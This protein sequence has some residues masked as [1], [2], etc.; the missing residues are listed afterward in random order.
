LKCKASGSTISSHKNGTQISSVTDSAI[1]GNLYAGLQVRMGQ[2][3]STHTCE[4]DNWQCSDD[5]AEA[6]LFCD[7]CQNATPAFVR[8]WSNDHANDAAAPDASGQNGYGVTL[9]NSTTTGAWRSPMFRPVDSP[10]IRFAFK[11][12]AANMTRNVILA[13]ANGQTNQC[14]IGISNGILQLD[15]YS[16][17]SRTNVASGS[18][19]LSNGAWYT[20]TLGVDCWNSGNAEVRLDN[21]RE[22]MASGVDFADGITQ[23]SRIVIPTS[24]TQNLGLDELCVYIGDP[25]VAGRTLPFM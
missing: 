13:L 3:S 21:V 14:S 17:G 22:I 24:N 10:W 5:V 4:W 12:S 16:G 19:T 11:P 15:R 6:N 25:D 8:L 2:Q 20:I 23:A 9:S 1:T 7:P 18:T